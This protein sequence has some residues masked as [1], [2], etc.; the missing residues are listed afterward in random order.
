MFLI[1]VRA[2][3]VLTIEQNKMKKKGRLGIK[4]QTFYFKLNTNVPLKAMF[5]D[6]AVNMGNMTSCPQIWSQTELIN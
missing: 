5:S 2:V 1:I 3:A 6:T 4:T